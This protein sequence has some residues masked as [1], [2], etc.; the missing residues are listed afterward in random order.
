MEDTK[1]RSHLRSRQC[2]LRQLNSHVGISKSEESESRVQELCTE[3]L[4]SALCDVTVGCG[5]P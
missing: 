1:L 4:V 5:C 2:G 3:S